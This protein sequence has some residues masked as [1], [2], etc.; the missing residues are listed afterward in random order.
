MKE[1][2]V[3][4][5]SFRRNY[6]PTHTT[7]LRDAF[8]KAMKKR[9][10]ELA[11]V[12]MISVYKNDCFALKPIDHTL[13]IH[14]MTPVPKQA[15]NF[16][17]NQDKLVEFMKWL[18]KQ[19]DAGILTVKELNQIGTGI[20]AMWTNI[21]LF[22]SYK[23]GLIRAR[24]E[25]INAGYN[26]PTIEESGG[27]NTVMGLPMHIDRLGIIYTRAYTELRGI[28]A[29]MDTMISRILA[30]GLAD[31]DGPALLARKIL[32]AINDS[33]LGQLGLVDSLGRFIPALRRAQILARTEVIR[34]HHSAMMQEYRNWGLLGLIVKAEWKTAGDDRV[35]ERCN[36]L[37]GKIF[38]LDQVEGL[39]PLHPMCR[40]I[41][42]P[43][44]E[45]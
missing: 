13:K 38:T 10:N 2:K 45:N 31:G 4:T 34:A 39:I 11:K 9:F 32:A 41:A 26:V 21:Y 16:A 44:I 30:Q 35:C 14:Q 5:E 25:L 3:Y 15:F 27:I 24:Q 33:D 23:R 12:I 28:T 20:D 18:Q 36:E 29:A 22:D 43:Y 37:E 7:A 1:V 6:D 8:A 42:L 17:M 19:V 40:C